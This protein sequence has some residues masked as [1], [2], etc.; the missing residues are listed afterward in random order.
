MTTYPCPECGKGKVKKTVRSN[1]KTK[2]RGQR[3]VVP[4]AVIGVCNQCGKEF[5]S[6][7]EIKRWTRL[8]EESLEPRCRPLSAEKVTEIRNNL[9]LTIQAFASLV[10]CTRQTVHNWE[11]RGRKV[12]QLG[13]ADLLLRLIE[14]STKYGEIDV[15]AWLTERAQGAATEP[16]GVAHKR[17]RP[18]PTPPTPGVSAAQEL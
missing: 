5:F 13:T 6:A 17:G 14:D 16:P 2:V 12:P 9:R 18:S 4:E 3:F 8:H 7:E 1:F 11:R 10:H 15:V